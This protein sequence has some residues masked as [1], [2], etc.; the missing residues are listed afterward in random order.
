MRDNSERELNIEESAKITAPGSSSAVRCHCP[1]CNIDI[2]DDTI[3]CPLCHGVVENTPE[4][5]NMEEA[6]ISI[7]YPDVS[8]KM[9]LLRLI[10]R[11]VLF[12]AIATEV[13]VALVNYITFNGIWWSCIVGLALFYGCVTLL[14]SFRKRR[15][16]QRIVQVQ[17][18]LSI[19]F[20]VLLDFVLGFNGWSIIYAI[21]I[22]LLSVDGIMIIL[23]IIRINDWQRFI[24]SEIATFVLSIVVLIIDICA[25]LGGVIFGLVVLVITGLILLGTIM[26]GSRSVSDEIKRRFMI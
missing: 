20:F 7:T 12:L 4:N 8:V 1:R 13:I 25:D 11:I 21:P 19:F 5:R 22:S 17:L 24:M 18:Y 10:I 14:Y 3:Q 23:M 9:R 6:S 15:S 16:I 2:V 26:I